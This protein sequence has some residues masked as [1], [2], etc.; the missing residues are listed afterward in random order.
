MKRFLTCFF[1][2]FLLISSF[3]IS[4]FA[5]NGV[6]VNL[7]DGEVING[8]RRIIVDKNDVDILVDGEKISTGKAEPEFKFSV[9]NVEYSEGVIYCDDSPIIDIPSSS[10][11]YVFSIDKNQLSEGDAVFTYIP[12]SSDTFEYGKECVYGTYNLDDQQVSGVSVVLPNGLSEYPDTAILYYPVVGS[13]EIVVKTEPFD[14]EKSYAIGDGWDA[15]TGNGGTTPETPLY[16]AFVFNSLLDKINNCSGVVADF[17]TAT[18]ADGRHQLTVSSNGE[19]LKTVEFYTDNTGPVINIDLPFGTPLFFESTVDFTATDDNE[20]D[21]LVCYIDNE[22]YRNGKSMKWV[23]LGKHVLTVVA[24]DKLGN[25]SVFCTQ[26]TMCEDPETVDPELQKLQTDCVLSSGAAEYEYD[27]GNSESFVF[28]YL[29]KTSE[30]GEMSVWA[31][32]FDLLEYVRIGTARSDVKCVFTVDDSAYISD[33]K[34]K[35]LV[36]PD[37]YVSQSDTVVWMTDTQYY[38]NFSDLRPVYELMLNYSVDLFKQ[39]KAGYLIHTGDIVDTFSPSEKAMEEWKFANEVH[40]I[41]D[42]AKMPYGVLAGNHDTNN[43]PADYSYYR[44]YFGKSR[45]ADNNWYGGNLDNNACHYDLITVAGNDLLFLYLGFGIEADD[46]TVAWANAVCK[47]YP[48][49]T[50]I[51]CTHSYL[52][53]DGNY[54]LNPSDKNSYNHSRAVEIM[55]YIIKPNNNVAAVFCGHVHGAMRV[56]RELDDGR[57]V[58]EILSDYQY[59]ETGKEPCHVA[60]GVTTDGEGYLRL[61]TFGEN[62]YMKQT[63]YS[64]LHDDYNYFPEAQDTFEITLNS[65]EGGITVIPQ[66]A[67]IYFENSSPMSPVVLILIISVIILIACTAVIVYCTLKKRK[68]KNATQ[69]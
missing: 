54:V 62:G 14:A 36:K 45:F 3:E 55:E 10:G 37:L 68:V 66:E 15:E 24:T 50:V 53:T 8:V 49:R 19:A 59:A 38:S 32:N 23:T 21:S 27:I 46:K 34:V 18:V 63:T 9:R 29:G 39:N 52:N 44:R 56:C 2:F 42:D 31:Y 26:F 12:A 20:V 22:I 30:M 4:V 67:A 43:T 35:I 51:L 58:W 41:L 13:S 69:S 7:T 5:G 11:D 33:G 1:L 17:D 6:D 65:V 16:V 61:V 40:E 57:F 47:A 25:K 28:E 60:N 64:P 48:N